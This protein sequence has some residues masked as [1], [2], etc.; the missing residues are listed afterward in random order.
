MPADHF[1]AGPVFHLK[2]LDPVSW[3]RHR[4]DLI[5]LVSVDITFF[6]DDEASLSAGPQSTHKLV[7][8]AEFR[9]KQR[10]RIPVGHNYSAPCGQAVFRRKQQVQFSFEI[11][12][13]K[14]VNN[15]LVSIDRHERAHI[16]A[17]IAVLDLGNLLDG[18][19]DVVAE[20]GEQKQGIECR[21]LYSA[22]IRSLS[23]SFI[24]SMLC[25]PWASSA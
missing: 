21:S 14:R 4:R 16:I 12:D 19:I 11:L 7:A 10:F 2:R 25:R 3:Q 13:R 1:V 24:S 20:V 5:G 9:R 18:K 17:Q 6:G 8:G 23:L 15:P 22:M